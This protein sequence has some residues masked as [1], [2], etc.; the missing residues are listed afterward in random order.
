ML[1]SGTAL[2]PYQI[3]TRQDLESIGTD[4]YTYSK[5]YKLMNDIDL[6]GEDW[7]PLPDIVDST[8]FSGTID[9]DNHKI[10]NMRIN[11]DSGRSNIGFIGRSSGCT[12]KNLCFENP[13]INTAMRNV[14]FVVAFGHGKFSNIYIKN[15]KIN[16]TGV[17]TSS[18]RLGGIVGNQPNGGS[19]K[20]EDIIVDFEYN[21]LNAPSTTTHYIGGIGG[22]I[23]STTFTNI[24]SLIREGTNTSTNYNFTGGI[25]GLWSYTPSLTNVYY[26]KTIFPK[27]LSTKPEIKALTTSQM[28]AGDLV[29]SDLFTQEIGKYPILNSFVVTP[30]SKVQIETVLSYLSQ[31]NSNTLLE[32][33]ATVKRVSSIKSL[34]SDIQKQ[35]KSV[36]IGTTFVRDI[37]TEVDYSIQVVKIGKETVTSYILP[38]NTSV[39]YDVEVIK[40]ITKII[41]SNLQPIN[42]DVIRQVKSV[43]EALSYVEAIF[44]SAFT[45]QLNAEQVQAIVYHIQNG[46]LAQFL[47]NQYSVYVEE[48]Q[49][50]K[51]DLQE[52]SE[53]FVKFNQS[54]S[55]VRE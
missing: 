21:V 47:T 14:G 45:K 26:D 11:I 34:S 42:S 28:Q 25:C 4:V 55:E 33:K 12:I 44:G 30:E 36:K 48:K 43:K 54:T 23:P 50:Q 38:I 7:I 17:S 35:I 32:K 37:V 5:H 9:G 22:S 40:I 15:G 1:G 46:T 41:Q 6:S 39:D 3:V 24:V 18:A 16:Y 31:V 52:N 53:V 2:D 10:L 8:V 29:L 51:N 19:P 20:Y 27:G 49:T 13:E